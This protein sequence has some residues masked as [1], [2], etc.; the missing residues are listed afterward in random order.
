M[1]WH[2][3]VASATV[4]DL[5]HPE[6]VIARDVPPEFGPLLAAALGLL[7]AAQS[8]VDA[9]RFMQWDKSHPIHA[10]AAAVRLAK[11]EGE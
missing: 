8:V 11:G 9:L 6:I 7:G 3:D 10:L 5:D 1:K 2:H 4:F